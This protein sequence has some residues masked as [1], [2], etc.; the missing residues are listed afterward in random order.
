MKEYFLGG[1]NLNSWVT[2]MSAQAA[3]MSGWLLMGLPAA[4]YIS[5]VSAS[6]IAIGLAVGT[7]LNWKIIAKRL[8]QFSSHMGDAITIPQYFQNRFF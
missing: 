7:Y 2:A 8:R 3:D 5:G 1:R 4:A 6:W